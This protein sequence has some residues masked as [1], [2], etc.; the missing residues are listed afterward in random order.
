MTIESFKLTV[1]ENIQAFKN[2]IDLCS[3]NRWERLYHLKDVLDE[4]HNKLS[5]LIP[6]DDYQNE[7]NEYIKERLLEYANYAINP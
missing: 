4:H 2:L 5:S 6:K 7:C 1:D 3:S